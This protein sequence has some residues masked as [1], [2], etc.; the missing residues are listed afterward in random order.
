MLNSTRYLT[1]R[2]KKRLRKH[3][4]RSSLH[5]EDPDALHTCKKFPRKKRRG[6]NSLRTVS[7]HNLVPE[8]SH[9]ADENKKNVNNSYLDVLLFLFFQNNK[10]YEMLL[11][12]LFQ[13]TNN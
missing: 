12:R 3:R 11:F 8:R 1:T 13:L 6:K 9:V 2:V 5:A 4:E 7:H 10:P